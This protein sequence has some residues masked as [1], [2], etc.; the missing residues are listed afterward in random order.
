MRLTLNSHLFFFS[1]CYILLC[2]CIKYSNVK[3][4]QKRIIYLL[5]SM[6]QQNNLNK[7]RKD[8]GIFISTLTMPLHPNSHLISLANDNGY[9]NLHSPRSAHKFSPSRRNFS[10]TAVAPLRLE[11]IRHPRYR[12][13]SRGRSF[14]ETFSTTRHK[15]ETSGRDRAFL[16]G[17][18]LGNTVTRGQKVG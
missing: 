2:S 18:K 10:S 8:K 4:S 16:T 11:T 5:A 6:I 14:D 13:K 1:R 3:L 7:R 15:R 17:G 12:K 9:P